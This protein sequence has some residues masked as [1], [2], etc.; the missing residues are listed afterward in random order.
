VGGV[1]DRWLRV[2]GWGLV[3]GNSKRGDEDCLGPFP[4]FFKS[5]NLMP[6]WNPWISR[7][8]VM[9]CWRISD[10]GV[11]RGGMIFG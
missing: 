11:E 6:F 1:R 4:A 7:E 10:M 5:G 2:V 9:R 8:R 3:A